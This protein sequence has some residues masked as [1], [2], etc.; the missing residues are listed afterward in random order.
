MRQAFKTIF[1]AYIL[2]NGKVGPKNDDI[3]QLINGKDSQA[4]F[5]G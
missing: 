2:I 1:I 5:N 3:N 4:Q